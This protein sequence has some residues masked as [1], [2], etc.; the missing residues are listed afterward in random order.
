MDKYGLTEE[1]YEKV[2]SDIEKKMSGLS[3]D[4][5]SEIISRYSVKCANDTL[6]K[7]SQTIFGG[8]F[9]SEYMKYKGYNSSPTTNLSKAR[10]VLGEQYVVKQQIHNDKLQLNKM[11]RDLVPSLTV[12]EELA[13]LMKQNDF[14]IEIPEYSFSPIVDTSKYTMVCPISD[15]HIG[16]IIDDC[17]GNSFNWDIANN[18]VDR[19]I[20]ECNKYI[21][22]YGIKNIIVIGCGDMI[23][24][25]IMRYT[26]NQYCEFYQSEQINRTIKLIFRMLVALSEKCNV[27]YSGLAGNHDRMSG[28]KKQSYEG[29]NANTIINEQIYNLVEASKTERITVMPVGHNDKEIKMNV[30]GVNCKFIHGDDIP[31]VDKNTLSKL[32]SS[33]NEFI[34]CLVVGHWHNFSCMSEN[35]GRYIVTN[36]CLSGRNTFSK[37]FLCASDASQTVMII[38][39]G[40]VELVKDVNLA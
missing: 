14:K 19:Y 23:E 5:W 29:D 36:G 13:E 31:K 26:Q 1:T 12:A 28:D 20:D 11:K 17:D 16:Y 34:D 32:I 33:D 18:R 3:D 24:N 2:L 10:E 8:Y 7:A 4:D 35:H 40:Q 30:N 15:F 9:V 21:Q 38:G 6:R 22:L 27:T 25:S 37:G 39:D